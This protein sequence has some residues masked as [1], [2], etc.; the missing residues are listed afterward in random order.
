[1]ARLVRAYFVNFNRSTQQ[2]SLHPIDQEYCYQ[3][4]STAAEEAFNRTLLHQRAAEYYVRQRK[5]QIEW[6][7]VESLTP[8]LAEFDHLVAAGEYNEAARLLLAIDKDYLW[9]WGQQALLAERHGRLRGRITDER[10]AH[11]NL[12]RIAWTRF[13]ANTDEA[14]KLFQ[15]LLEDARNTG[16][17]QA[18]A[19]ALDDLAQI[20][21]RGMDIPTGFQ[22]H[23][24]AL[25]IYREI[26]DRRGQAEALGGM[27]ASVAFAYPEIAIGYLQEALAI[28]R[29]LDNRHSLAFVLLSLGQTALNDLEQYGQAV[30]YLEQALTLAREINNSQTLVQG[31]VVLGEAYAFQGNYERAMGYYQESITTAERASGEAFNYGY[32]FATSQMAQAQAL[33]GDLDVGIQT[34]RQFLDVPGN[35]DTP[36][37]GIVR[38]TLSVL[39]AVSGEVRESRQISESVLRIPLPAIFRIYPALVLTRAGERDATN[40]IFEKIVASVQQMSPRMLPG[41]RAEGL[42]LSAIAVLTGDSAKVKE[43]VEV[44]RRLGKPPELIGFRQFQ[45]MLLDMLMECPGGDVLAPV[46]AVLVD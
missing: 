27:G 5:P 39:L 1:L 7:S 29:D 46:R 16:D 28:Q 45:R 17:R 15:Q 8:Q 38:T 4:I 25:E 18:E 42:A 12:R 21:R 20:H 31:L 41:I 24:Q 23:Q 10:L 3:Q 33:K 26:G 44:Y 19:D 22:L 34:L 36:F 43:A 2:F 13:W 14:A 30:A 6:T 35:L 32:A 40:R 37:A 11:Q 9:D